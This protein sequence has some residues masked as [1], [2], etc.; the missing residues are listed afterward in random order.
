MGQK[1]L[2]P[3]QQDAF[4][5]AADP[6]LTSTLSKTLD[7]TSRLAVST[8]RGVKEQDLRKLTNPEI[9]GA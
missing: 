7:V 1:D 9:N 3:W 5:G 6:A 4:A 8:G 2:R